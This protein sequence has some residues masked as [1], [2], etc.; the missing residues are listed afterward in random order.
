V[1]GHAARARACAAV[2]GDP[3]LAASVSELLDARGVCASVHASIE[4]RGETLVVE[5]DGPSGPSGER[6]ERVVTD[7]GT[8]ATVIESWSTD[9]SAPLLAARTLAIVPAPAPAPVTIERT[10]SATRPAARGVQLFAAGE[11]SYASDHT[12]WVGI[13]IGACVMLGPVCA[14]ARVRYATVA[15][16]PGMWQGQL[17]RRGVEV[18]FG[19]DIPFRIGSATLSPG[20]AAGLGSTHTHMDVPMES[21]APDGVHMGSETGG[22]RADIHATLSIPM[23]PRLALDLSFTFDITQATHVES[24]SSVPMPDDPL[25]LA[26]FGIGLRYGGL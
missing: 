25:A 1:L 3:A 6:I 16:G 14:A 24:F 19:G 11:T 15:T 13:Q 18:L 5:V 21:M 22:L 9:V 8:A 20:F 26:R 2:D 23:S 17:D 7:L 10:A 12:S 4:R